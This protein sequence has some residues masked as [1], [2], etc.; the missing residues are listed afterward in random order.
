MFVDF[1]SGV[2]PVDVLSSYRLLSSPV[3]VVTRQ[4]SRKCWGIALKAEG[5]TYYDQKGNKILSDGHHVVLLPKGAEYAWTCTEPGVCMVIDFDAL[6]TG[7]EIRS[8]ELKDSEPVLSAFA[9]LERLSGMTD[10]ASKLETMQL[11]YGLLAF[12]SKAEHKK[13]VPSGKRQLLA[14]A[15]DHITEKYADPD[16]Q[17]KDLAQ[18]C[19]MSTVY[20]RKTFEAVY[21]IPPIRYLH[22]LRIQK[23][24]AILSG[25]YDS[26][27]QV[28]E[29]T[30]YS[31][32]YHFSKMFKL[33]T[34][35]NPTS[36]A[37]NSR[38]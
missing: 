1:G 10:T 4:K 24:K 37:K 15:I 19:N 2:T 16:I 7:D 31:S 26:V 25:D 8:V 21:G 35:E 33:Y 12:L 36:Y 22:R 14:P 3:G 13:Y 28:A 30:G 27:R 23:A 38:K 29:S 6:E 5:K 18:L 17:N 9:K 32:V 11:L 34:G 20:F